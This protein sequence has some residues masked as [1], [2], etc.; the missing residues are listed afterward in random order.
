MLMD[1]RPDDADRLGDL[2]R[3]ITHWAI[4]RRYWLS[5][6]GTLGLI[7]ASA[8]LWLF[9]PYLLGVAIDGLVENDWYG[10]AYLAGLQVGVLIIGGA[11]RYYD[12]RVY[13]R[14][15]RDI[16][17]EAVSA[18]QAAGLEITR[19]AARANMLR[20]VVNF[21]EF[22]VPS[23]I[24]ATID[25]VGS[26]ALLSFLSLNVFYASLGA[27]AA[28]L[29]SSFLFGGQLLRLNRGYND[30]LEQEIDAYQA[31][32]R[33][34]TDAHL[35]ALAEW[36]IRRSDTQ[37]AIFGLTSF[38]LMGVVL[39]ALYDTVSVQQAAIGTVFAVISYV[40]RFQIATFEFPAAYQQIIRTL[41]I[42]RR[43]NEAWR[44]PSEEMRRDASLRREAAAVRLMGEFLRERNG[45]D[46]R[47]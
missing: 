40:R 7:M 46:R 39:Y 20:E 30:Q 12:T 10:V 2:G 8:G 33:Q 29:L 11:R 45:D 23:I 34:R 5:I 16:G 35:S 27:L 26:L 15:Y 22:R 25:L 4:F 41:E 43:I 28:I 24:R 17:A 31:R 13:A 1:G 18:A 47:L 37:V 14:I 42:T 21:F 38:V 44:A 9:Q 36:Q 6:I 19:T 32:S 3:R